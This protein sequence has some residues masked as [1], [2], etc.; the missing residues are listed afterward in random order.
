MN[1]HNIR[2]NVEFLFSAKQARDVAD[3]MIGHQITT[4]QTGSAGRRVDR[5]MICERLYSR[6][7]YYFAITLDR[8]YAVSCHSKVL[9][10]CECAAGIVSL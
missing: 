5:A 8:K 1:S 7:E 6:R 9:V 10:E 3:K 2:I 4:K